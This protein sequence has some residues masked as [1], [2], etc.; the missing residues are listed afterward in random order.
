MVVGVGGEV[1]EKKTFKKFWIESLL[2]PKLIQLNF[3]GIIINKTSSLFGF[4]NSQKRCL[5]H[6]EDII[7]GVQNSAIK[8]LGK[9]KADKIY[10][11]AGTEL[12]KIYFKFVGFK[13]IPGFLQ[14][15]IL[16]R[17]P[18]LLK[19]NGTT[20]ASK[21]IIKKD[22]I[23]LCGQDN[24]ICRKTKNPSFMEGIF[25]GMLNS[26]LGYKF[27]PKRKCIHCKK[28][29]QISFYKKEKIK[30]IP[31]ADP[32]FIKRYNFL[33]I[34]KEMPNTHYPSMQ[35]FA[36]QGK[37]TFENG[38][39]AFNNLT[40]I[41]TEQHMFSI[42]ADKYKK[43]GEAKEFRIAT[44]KNAES[45]FEKIKIGGTK[46]KEIKNI[47]EILCAF[48]WG[49]PDLQ[50][51]NKQIKI[52]LKHPP[53]CEYAPL[54]RAYIINGYM[55]KIYKKKYILKNIKQHSNPTSLSFLYEEF[56]LEKNIKK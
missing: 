51:N 47:L 4:K 37:T 11:E 9:K 34:P 36:K 38:K 12:G 45:F 30:K 22:C 6:F 56:E 32:F 7:A 52:T 21:I 33:N 53:V 3:P 18:S 48:G 13:K 27:I 41:P 20:L 10:N 49:I 35:D 39:K 46:E 8:N 43:N 19:A 2:M 54:Y 44:I 26:V 1:K 17:L 28:Q 23:T 5:Y 55:N 42:L 16:E 15:K 40:I 24:I 31:K 25:A 14:K 29:C 50:E